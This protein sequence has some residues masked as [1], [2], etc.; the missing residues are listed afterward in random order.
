MGRARTVLIGSG[1]ISAAVAVLHVILTFK[2]EWWKDIAGSVESPL[3]SMAEQGSPGTRVASAG[4]A[5]LFSIWAMYAFSGAGLVRALPWLRAVLVAV[6]VT[7]LLRGLA[8]IPELEMVRA[9]GYPTQYVVFSGI[10]L[11]TG[12]LYLIGAWRLVIDSAG[13]ATG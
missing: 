2:P 9:E 7:Y 11:L 3:A 12:S 5:V 13:R 4:L 1:S 8:I 10:S 6:G